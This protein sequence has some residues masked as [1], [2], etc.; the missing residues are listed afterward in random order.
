[1]QDEETDLSFADVNTSS[2]PRRPYTAPLLSD[3]SDNKNAPD[4]TGRGRSL[5]L[6]HETGREPAT[7]ALATCS[8]PLISLRFPAKPPQGAALGTHA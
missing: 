4:R 6:E 5:Y 2:A 3:D 1:M 7:P 8:D